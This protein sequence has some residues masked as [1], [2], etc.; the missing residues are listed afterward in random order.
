LALFSFSLPKVYG[1]EKN[2]GDNLKVYLAYISLE[3]KTLTRLAVDQPVNENPSNKEMTSIQII[4]RDT[5]SAM[6]ELNRFSI[7][8][9][10]NSIVF[11]RN[12]SDNLNLQEQENK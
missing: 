7:Q 3:N 10:S 8:F 6:D 5:E 1:H 11:P 2:A 9:D 4:I 12:L